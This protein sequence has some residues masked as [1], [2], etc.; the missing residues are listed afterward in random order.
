MERHSW[1]TAIRCLEVALHPNTGDEEVLA[2]VNGYRRTAGGT[3]LAELCGEFARKGGSVVEPAEWAEKFDRLHRENLELRR[4]L[5]M[6]NASQAVTV[7]RVD[8]TE[9]RLRDLGDELLAARR[10][11]N[12]AEQLLAEL[13]SAHTE[14]ADGLR[15]RIADLRGA[16]DETR[17]RA[18]QPEAAMS[19]PLFRDVLAA[20][21]H[22]PGRAHAPVRHRPDPG[23]AEIPPPMSRSLWTA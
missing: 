2:A 7:H 13:S 19:S 16:L 20:A 23:G 6:A 15:H 18:A 11:A 12:E 14:I 21:R 3:P 22:E 5:E 4:K 8:E 9:Q 17:R 10:R 1:E